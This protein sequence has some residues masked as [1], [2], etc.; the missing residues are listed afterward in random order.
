MAH[1]LVA[2]AGVAAA[3]IALGNCSRPRQL[4]VLGDEGLGTG[5]TIVAR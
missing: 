5:H 4:E 1:H 2:L 3:H